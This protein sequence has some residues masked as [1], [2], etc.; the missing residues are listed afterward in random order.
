MELMLPS[1]ALKRSFVGAD[2][3][4]KKSESDLAKETEAGSYHA[5]RIGDIGLLIPQDSICEVAEELAYCQLPNTNAVL[6]GM[7]N[8]RG[9]I[10]PIF[11]LH[12]LFGFTTNSKMRRKVLII[13]HGDKA[14]AVMIAE[15]PIRIVITPDQR[16][17]N[18]PPIPDTL[19]PYIKNCYQENGV[20]F[21]WDLN[22]FFNGINTFIQ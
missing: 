2:A 16:L 19:Q 12:E 4:N 18:L 20:W 3:F 21:N 5:F 15:L 13:G 22:G 6:Y 9:N 10:I 7:A 11:D 17:R 14:A 8:L 1:L